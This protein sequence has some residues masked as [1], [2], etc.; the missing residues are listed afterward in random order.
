MIPD[1]KLVEHGYTKVVATHIKGFPN[2]F[3]IVDSHEYN[4]LPDDV[5][6]NLFSEP[7]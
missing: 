7:E 4:A 1:S 6:N 3:L 5:R 2:E